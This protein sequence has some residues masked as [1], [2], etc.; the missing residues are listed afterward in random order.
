MAHPGGNQEELHVQAIMVHE[1]PR[2]IA[3]VEVLHVTLKW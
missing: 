3:V 1:A 2:I